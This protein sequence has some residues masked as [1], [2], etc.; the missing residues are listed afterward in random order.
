MRPGWDDL[1]D[2]FL[3]FGFVDCPECTRRLKDITVLEEHWT[4]GH[5]DFPD[6]HPNKSRKDP[7][8]DPSSMADH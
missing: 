7:Y 8:D 6:K 1:F 2:E 3:S 5:F 4:L